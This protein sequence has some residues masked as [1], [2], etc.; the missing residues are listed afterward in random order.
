MEFGFFIKCVVVFYAAYQLWHFLKAIEPYRDQK[1][2]RI[3]IGYACTYR[4]RAIISILLFLVCIHPRTAEIF[5]GK[6][7][8]LSVSSGIESGTN[9]TTPAPRS[10]S[11]GDSIAERGP[12]PPKNIPPPVAPHAIIEQN[13]V[14][15]PTNLKATVPQGG[16]RDYSH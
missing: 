10:V 11:A 15:S 3:V 8:P 9:T 13:P 16:V 12:R 7:E 4:W 6:K 1:P 14:A 5:W 2:Y